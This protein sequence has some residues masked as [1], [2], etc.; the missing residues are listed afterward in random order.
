[1]R[2]GI[3]TNRKKQLAFAAVAVAAVALGGCATEDYVNERIATVQSS[4][5]ALAGQMNSRVGAV[6]A[7]TSEHDTRL[8]AVEKGKFNYQ[9]VGETALLFDT[10]SY[11]LKAEEAAKLDTALA[12]L[13]AADRS[14]YIEI[15]GFADP[16]GGAKSNRELGLRRA[17]E[18]YNYLRDQGVALNRMMLFSHGEE[19]QI[20]DGN[21]D[22]NLR[23]VDTVV[24]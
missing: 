14:A 6:E 24:Q 23:V 15:E 20:A 19:Q 4:V 17:R 10:G 21:N 5:D 8:A 22:M 16:R 11:R 12:G 9:K 2:T 7:K 13:K 18:V 3:M 1:M